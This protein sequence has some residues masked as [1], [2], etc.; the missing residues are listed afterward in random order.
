MIYPDPENEADRKIRIDVG[1]QI[2]CTASG[3]PA[4][5]Y[6][7]YSEDGSD[8]VP[9]QFLEIKSNMVKRF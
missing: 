8:V 6:Y 3:R 1:E 7:W 9:G 4:P 2:N 5:S